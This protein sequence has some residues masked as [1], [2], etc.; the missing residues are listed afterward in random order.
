MS[1][2]K[3][4]AALLKWMLSPEVYLSPYRFVMQA[5]AWGENDLKQFD[6]PRKW[7]KDVMLGIEDYLKD[8]IR[9]KG[10]TGKLPDFYRHA[11]ASGRGPGKSALVGML[12]HWFISTRIGG[13]VWVAA[14]GEPQLRT[15]TFPEISKWVARGINNEFFDLNSM[16]IQPATWFRNYIESKEGLDRSTKYYYVSGQLWSEENPDA[17]AGAHNFDGE[18]SIFDESSGIPDSIW[19]V[20]E[21][22]FTEDIPDRFWFAFSNPRKNSGA[23][24]ECFHKKRDLWRTTQLDSRT[25]EGISHTTFENIIKQYGEDSD[26]ARVEVKGEFPNTGSNQFI[27]N[28]VARDAAERSVDEDVGAP[29]VM[30]VD[31]A[32][33]GEDRSVIAFRRGRDARSIPWQ[34]YKKLDTQQ[35][36]HRVA[37]AADTYQPDAIFIDGGGVGGGVVDALKAM[38]YKVIEVQAGGKPD[39]SSRYRNKRIEMWDRM[40]QWLET[41]CIPD[42]KDLVLDLITPSYKWHDVTNQL[43]LESK[44]DMRKRGEASPDMAEALVQTFSKPIA[45]NDIKVGRNKSRKVPMA[46]DIDYDLFAV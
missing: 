4:Q 24:Y 31:V 7:Q 36:A 13:S 18:M 37:R 30:G 6:G 11:V 43:I 41:G 27:G 33:F 34:V 23:F 14:N 1:L 5:Y 26:E 21:G 15:K 32:R 16:S 2:S 12:S 3:N 38:K 25:V 17:F 29:L 22:V 9:T 40:K 28:V 10:Q 42:D 46:Q 44:E 20:Q 8:A 35:L 39:D 19:T 45:R